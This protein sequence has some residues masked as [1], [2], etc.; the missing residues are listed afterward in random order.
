MKESVIRKKAIIELDKLNYIVWWPYDNRWAREQ[1]IFGV[2]D[3]IAIHKKN[4]LIQFVQITTVSNIS[5]RKKKVMSFLD[6]LRW[7]DKHFIFSVWGYNQKNKNFK[8][9]QL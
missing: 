9:M 7:R 5:A 3:I 8:Q 2:F 4:S 6:K 1:D